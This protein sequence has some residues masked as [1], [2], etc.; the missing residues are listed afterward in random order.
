MSTPPVVP[1]DESVPPLPAGIPLHPAGSPAAA[2]TAGRRA[3]PNLL[4]IAVALAVGVLGGTGAIPLDRNGLLRFALGMVV[5]LNLHI[6][7]Y[8]LL[9]PLSGVA[10]VWTSLGVGRW[11]GHTT[12]RGRLVVFRLL[13]LIPFIACQVIVGRPGLRRRMWACA[14]AT[15]LAEA[16]A[17]AAL[18]AAGGPAASVG[19]G[20]AAVTL[21][22][23][24]AQPG[25]VTSPAWRLFRLPF[26]D[27]DQA[28]AEWVHDPATL[29]AARA[30]CAGRID[31][32]RAALDAA[33]AAPGDASPRRLAME[34]SLAL[35]EGRC[36]AAARTAAELR[37]RSH[38]PELRRGALQ[39]YACAVA[40]GI[41]AGHW[42][43]ADAMPY[44]DAALAALRAESKAAAL[45]G[46]DLAAMEALFRGRPQQAVKLATL[47]AANAATVHVRARALLT[48]AAAHTAAGHPEL[49]RAPRARAAALSPTLHTT[50]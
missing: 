20:L 17:S 31:L 5:G 14:A 50:R 4:I 25:R 36:D 33:P 46:T 24:A 42:R 47:A 23:L 10:T 26:G 29:A 40:D 16:V 21:L 30:A 38:A 34:A 2:H 39:L 48:L 8:W 41:A 44:F 22:V 9:G 35:C 45:R 7:A 19:W 49:S 13:P 3:L 32:A 6:V 28:L 15:L 12:R 27:N 11:L 37:E 43:A 18:V 1:Q